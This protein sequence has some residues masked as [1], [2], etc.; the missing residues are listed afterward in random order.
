MQVSR[1]DD[2]RRQKICLRQILKCHPDAAHIKNVRGRKTDVNDA[3]WL[4][5]LMGR[6]LIRG[7]FVPDAQT[8]SCALCCEPVL[9]RSVLE[10]DGVVSGRMR[11][12]G[13]AARSIGLSASFWFR[14][15]HPSTLRIAI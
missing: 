12:R 11:I 3:T 5:D 8:R 2:R 4:A 10:F 7:S 14:V 1:R 6:G 9:S 13:Q 15:C